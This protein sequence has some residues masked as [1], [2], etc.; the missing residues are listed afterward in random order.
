MAS[1]AIRVFADKAPETFAFINPDAVPT[2]SD[3]V[4]AWRFQDNSEDGQQKEVEIYRYSDWLVAS[5]RP[6]IIGVVETM[7]TYQPFRQ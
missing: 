5:P 1:D 6:P 3:F 4:A 2:P 7:V